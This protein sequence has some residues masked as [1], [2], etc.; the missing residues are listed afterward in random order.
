M[1]PADIR[2]TLLEDIRQVEGDAGE[3]LHVTRNTISNILDY[4]L[5]V[6]QRLEALEAGL[7]HNKRRLERLEGRT[8]QLQNRGQ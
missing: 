3:Y 6:E 1:K 2:R 4:L 5:S 7:D 8:T